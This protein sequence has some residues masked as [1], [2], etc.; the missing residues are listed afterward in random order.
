MKHT[1]FATL[2]IASMIYS[3]PNRTITSSFAVE[4][5]SV[6]VATPTETKLTAA[7]AFQ[8]QQFGRAV[9]ID[10]NTAVI[11]AP[12]FPLG[13]HDPGSAYVYVKT[14]SGWQF[15]QKL[16]GFDASPLSQ[17]GVSVD[18]D[19][20]TIVV[21]AHGENNATGAAYVFERS[22]NTWLFKQKL[23]GS[24]NSP[25]DSFGLS[26]AVDGNTIVCGAFGNSRSPFNQTAEGT[27]YVFTLLGNHWLETQKLTAS[28]ESPNNNFGGKVA[29]DGETII[30]G[31]IGNADFAGAVY[32]FDFDG[33]SWIEQDKLTAQDASPRV[34]FGYRLG[35]SGDTI[36]V[37]S[38]GRSD[39][40]FF[41]F[42]AAYIFRR[43]P[44]GWH[45]QKRITTDDVVVMGRIE[46]MGRFGLTVA[47]SGDMVIVGS[48]ND[49]T[50]AFWSGTAYIYRRNGES[51]WQLDQQ[52]FPSDAARDDQ[53]GG[54]IAISGETVL[55]GAWVK[56]SPIPFAGAAYIYEF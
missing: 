41:Q 28:D 54:A 31:A 56:F 48:P 34:I 43:T 33:S 29:I 15:Q 45:Q 25:G 38:E 13:T 35:I 7:D 51:S 22:N 12:T 18:V 30:V 23:A 49:P 44:S 2:L 50:L 32:V 27:T 26:V 47:V 16:T 52:I 24:E 3:N 20:D 40:P 17:F 53:F 37:A 8:D 14:T 1:I 9:A 36:V 21:G 5:Q 4:T 46:N 39:E 55:I 19:G 11:G 6:A 42:S 10:G